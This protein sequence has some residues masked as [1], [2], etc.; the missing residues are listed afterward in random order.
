MKA[1]E[2]K[3]NLISSPALLPVTPPS[4]LAGDTRRDKS[5]NIK[6][7]KAVYIL[8]TIRPYIKRPSL[9]Q[10]KGNIIPPELNLSY[11]SF[12]RQNVLSVSVLTKLIFPCFTLIL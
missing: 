1:Q 8:E 12:T 9:L 3:A 6:Y 11:V 10:R 7:H 5:K 2:E 4:P